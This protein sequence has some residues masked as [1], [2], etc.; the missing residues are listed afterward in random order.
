MPAGA[1]S[2]PAPVC[3]ERNG[4]TLLVL[5][6]ERSPKDYH[7]IRTLLNSPDTVRVAECFMIWSSMFDQESC[8]VM[9]KNAHACLGLF[10]QPGKPSRKEYIFS[11]LVAILPVRINAGCK[12]H[13]YRLSVQFQQEYC[14][15]SYISIVSSINA[16]ARLL[17]RQPQLPFHH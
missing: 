15:K 14:C 9:P 6:L 10:S 4:H 1:C 3:L 11:A 5:V 17:Q 16:S 13:L 8:R 7:A 12:N 2:L